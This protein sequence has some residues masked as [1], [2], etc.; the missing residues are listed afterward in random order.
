MVR[1]GEILQQGDARKVVLV[2]LERR[3]IRIH[4]QS[5]HIPGLLEPLTQAACPAEEIDGHRT[6]LVLNPPLESMGPRRIRVRGQLE[7]RKPHK[8]YL[9]VTRRHVQ[10]TSRAGSAV[11]RIEVFGELASPHAKT[12]RIPPGSRRLP[13]NASP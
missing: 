12:R 8:L 3:S 6:L 9:K 1:I 11:D 7:R 5:D 2:G 4:R 10:F 13:T